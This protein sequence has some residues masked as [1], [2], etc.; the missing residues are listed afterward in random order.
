MSDAIPTFGF[1]IANT[2]VNI[3]LTLALKSSTLKLQSSEYNNIS[4]MDVTAPFNP[5]DLFSA[6]GL[7]VVITGG[8]SGTLLT[9]MGYP[10]IHRAPLL[11]YSPQ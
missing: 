7:V 2:D 1:G 6:K 8:G 5:A 4:I 3:I 10:S 9:L 11:R